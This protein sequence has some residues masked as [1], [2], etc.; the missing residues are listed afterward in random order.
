MNWI[1]IELIFFAVIV[2]LA[3]IGKYRLSI[4]LFLVFLISASILLSQHFHTHYP[5]EY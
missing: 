4:I 5:L 2:L 1:L 3:W